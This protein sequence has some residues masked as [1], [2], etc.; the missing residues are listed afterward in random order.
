MRGEHT[1]QLSMLCHISLE[2]RV[3]PSHP[4][5]AIKR[6]ADRALADIDAKLS[7]MYSSR[8]RHSVPPER[9]LKATLLM[10]L[11]TRCA[12]TASG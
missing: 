4:L 3:P 10:A 1:A 6:L 7:A 9:L 11:R 2:S 12:A 5:R 8:G